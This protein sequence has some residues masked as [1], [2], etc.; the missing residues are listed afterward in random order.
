MER[1]M[2]SFKTSVD[3]Y[4]HIYLLTHQMQKYATTKNNRKK[5]LYTTM[6][7][8]VPTTSPFC[9]WNFTFCS[10]T[11]KYINHFLKMFCNVQH[12]LPTS[13]RMFMFTFVIYFP[14]LYHFKRYER[15]KFKRG[16]SNTYTQISIDASYKSIIWHV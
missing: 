8:T 9:Y 2:R 13:E 14:D 10:A 1:I 15:I 4:V 12:K 5:I 7:E 3:Q 16:R 6:V 11:I